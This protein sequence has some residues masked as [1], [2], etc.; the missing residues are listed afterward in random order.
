MHIAEHFVSS[1][2]WHMHRQQLACGSGLTCATMA[3]VITMAKIKILNRFMLPQLAGDIKHENPEGETS[4]PLTQH[5]Q[6]VPN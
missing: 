4:Q 2:A 5:K 3:V 6:E 1:L